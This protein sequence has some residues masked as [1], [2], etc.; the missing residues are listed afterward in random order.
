[1]ATVDDVLSYINGC[2]GFIDSQTSLL[3]EDVRN[4]SVRAMGLSLR[5]QIGNIPRL[6]PASATALNTAIAASAFTPEVKT[7]MGQAVLEKLTWASPVSAAEDNKGQ[8]MMHPQNS[9]AATDWTY[10]EDLA[11]TNSQVALRIRHR[12][13]LLSLPKPS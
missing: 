12:L 1:M 11:K 2:K 10:V 5:T 3:P 8:V 4:D 7:D 13:A 9:M 6:T